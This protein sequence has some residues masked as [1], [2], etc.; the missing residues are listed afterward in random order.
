MLCLRLQCWHSC[1]YFCLKYFIA[2]LK[3]VPI[4]LLSSQ[5]SLH[6]K[7]WTF[8]FCCFG[9]FPL[10]LILLFPWLF[11]AML[12]LMPIYLFLSVVCTVVV[13]CVYTYTVHWLWL[14]SRLISDSSI[15]KLCR[16]YS[17][18][19][20]YTGRQ[21]TQTGTHAYGLYSKVALAKN[22][23]WAETQS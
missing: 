10:V 14:Y 15:Y 8:D 11:C 5:N 9:L 18:E 2:Q 20:C 12:T 3:L 17:L 22:S 7:L 21:E 4:F 16:L 6:H 13:L 1:Q 23:L 19:I